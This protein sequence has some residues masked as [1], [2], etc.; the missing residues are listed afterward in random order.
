[1]HTFRGRLQVGGPMKETLGLIE[2]ARHFNA[3]TDTWDTCELRHFDR[4][5]VIEEEHLRVTRK[6]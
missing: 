5:G 6:K 4:T 3:E 2:L 1:M